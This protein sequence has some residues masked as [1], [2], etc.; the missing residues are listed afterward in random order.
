M[1]YP[2]NAQYCRLN[3][4]S[5]KELESASSEEELE[6]LKGSKCCYISFLENKDNSDWYYFCGK[7]S[8]T[9]FKK[10]FRIHKR[11]KY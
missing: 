2:L 10:S 8:S 7:V 3:D 11:V 1:E 9:D 6:E 5:K 4:P